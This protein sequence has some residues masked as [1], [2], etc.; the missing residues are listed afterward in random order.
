MNERYL[1]RLQGIKSNIEWAEEILGKKE[2]WHLSGEIN[3][4]QAHVTNIK[5][6][7]AREDQWYLEEIESGDI[8]DRDNL[9]AEAN[10][11]KRSI[12]TFQKKMY[13]SIEGKVVSRKGSKN[14]LF[15]VRVIGYDPY[16]KY[17]YIEQQDLTPY[18]LLENEQEKV[19]LLSSLIR[20]N[21]GL[22][23][24]ELLA[25]SDCALWNSKEYEEDVEFR[26]KLKSLNK[27]KTKIM[28]KC[29]DKIDRNFSRRNTNE[30][31]TSDLEDLYKHT[32]IF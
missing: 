25:H 6:G 3:R 2:Y 8:W 12:G 7:I 31:Y 20:T 4:M 15:N 14:P 26:K 30:R 5:R 18:D 1:E 22:V 21:P 19:K 17:P 9:L 11:I 13:L 16:S 32:R 29:E 23:L 28:R 27:S 24:Q 10:M